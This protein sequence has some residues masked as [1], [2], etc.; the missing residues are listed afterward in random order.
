MKTKIN[1]VEL[2]YDLKGED[3][4]IVFIHGLGASSLLWLPQIDPFSKHFKVIAYDMRGHG[5]SDVPT[6]GYSIEQHTEDLRALLDYLGISRANVCGLSMGGMI[7]LEFTLRYM[8]RVNKLMLTGTTA[9]VN[10]FREGISEWF[11]KDTDMVERNRTRAVTVDDF[12]SKAYSKEFIESNKPLVE[13]VKERISSGPYGGYVG[14]AR[15]LFKKPRWSMVDKLENIKLPTS[16]FHGSKDA[17]LPVEAALKIHEKIKNSELH[18]YDSGHAVNVEK[19]RQWNET[20][21]EFLKTT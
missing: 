18:I 15:E 4:P 6:R 21:I 17:M 8:T 19:Y 12:V 10:Y 5:L 2:Y 14:S 7:A 20:A 11:L 16:I 9:D 3:A 1:E 13:R